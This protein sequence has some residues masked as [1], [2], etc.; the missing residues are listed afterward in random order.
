MV[1]A[2]SQR[3]VTAF[4]SWATILASVAMRIERLKY[5]ARNEPEQPATV[6]LSKVEVEATLVL[7]RSDD[8]RSPK[9]YVR[10][11][12]PTIAQAVN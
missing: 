3:E 5:L 10:S 1:Y 7:Y 11:Q 9:D 8:G 12:V 2:Y 4:E 6:E